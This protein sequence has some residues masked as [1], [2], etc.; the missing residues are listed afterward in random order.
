MNDDEE[1]GEGIGPARPTFNHIP[2]IRNKIRP[3][4]GFDDDTSNEDADFSEFVN[5]HGR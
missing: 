3:I 4:V 1:Q 2:K 5:P